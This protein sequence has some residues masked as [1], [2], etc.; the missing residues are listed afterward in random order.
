MHQSCLGRCLAFACLCNSQ[1]YFICTKLI[2]CTIKLIYVKVSSQLT[3]NDAILR[4]SLL[5]P[6]GE[7]VRLKHFFFYILDKEYVKIQD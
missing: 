2:F 7:E 4:N 5:V 6:R 1:N 3:V